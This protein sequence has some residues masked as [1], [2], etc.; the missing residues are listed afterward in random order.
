[1][2][3][4][5]PPVSKPCEPPAGIAK[6]A[7]ALK[8]AG[9]DCRV[10]DTNIAGILDLLQKPIQAKDTWSKRASGNI[11]KNLQALRTKEL[12]A[13]IDRY[14][15]AVMDINR[16]L[17]VT[18]QRAGVHISLSNYTSSILS[19]VRSD[20]LMQAAESFD[21]NPFFSSFQKRLTAYFT[22]KEPEVVGF[23]VN[24]MSQAL[25]AF[26]M[27][28]FIKNRFPGVRIVFGGGLVTSWMSIP[29]FNNPFVGLIDDLVCGPGEDILLEMCGA[30]NKA[31]TG[32]L[33]YDYSLFEME[34]YLS[35]GPVIPFSTARGCYWQ[36]CAF[37]P[38]KSEKGGYQPADIRDV[39]RDIAR[40]KSQV[41]PCLIHF[42]DNALSPKFLKHVIKNPPKA[43]WYGFARI[44][45]HL[46][47]PDFARGLKASECV[48][49]KLG[50]ESGDQAVLDALE[51]GINL[52]TVSKALQNLKKAGIA[53]YVYLLFGTPAESRM[54]AEKTLEFTLAHAHAID[55]LNLAV[56]NLPA[57][58]EDAKS[59]D[60]VEFYRGD[61]SLY[62]EFVH[63]HG[64]NR[65][66]VRQFLTKEFKKPPSIKAIINN[67][68]PYFTSNHSPFIIMAD[69]R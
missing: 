32:C 22:E 63:P 65:D 13:G 55:F 53:A 4:I 19:P 66:K 54:S 24:F 45:D 16:V 17:H 57:T 35:P 9:I 59:L 30:G 68:P 67:D 10:Y 6:L 21:E 51:K 14:K 41:D 58:S 28:G 61:L 62:K 8:S 40:L 25:C 33:G 34:Q 20:D 27:A 47:D 42:V 64:W 69:R 29:A 26:A 18:G 44:T 38:E 1:M 15:R 39:S 31:L 46:A 23:S 2:L 37:C 3:L 36:K 48:M 7:G 52:N 12:Y 60:T 5:H 43:P 56:F 11:E 50:V 49:L